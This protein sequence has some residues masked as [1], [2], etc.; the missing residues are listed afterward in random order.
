MTTLGITALFGAARSGHASVVHALLSQGAVLEH[1]SWPVQPICIAAQH[2]LRA[3]ATLTMQVTSLLCGCYLTRVV[4]AAGAHLRL[5]RQHQNARYGL[6]P[7]YVC[8]VEWLAGCCE[9]L[10]SKN[11]LMVDSDL[12]WGRSKRSVRR[13]PDRH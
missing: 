3:A 6:V 2:G 9:G 13:G 11:L 5:R 7:A 8:V 10:A 1:A 4:V 12:S